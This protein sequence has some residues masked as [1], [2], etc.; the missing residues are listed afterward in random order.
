MQGPYW[1]CA[2]WHIL[3]GLCA[4]E[5]MLTSCPFPWQPHR[6]PTACV[7]CPCSY[8]HKHKCTFQHHFSSFCLLISESTEKAV[9]PSTHRHSIT[10]P[11]NSLIAKIYPW[12]I[13]TVYVVNRFKIKCHWHWQKVVLGFVTALEKKSVLVKAVSEKGYWFFVCCPRQKKSR[14]YSFH[15]GCC[16]FYC[17]VFMGYPRWF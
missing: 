2:T 10:F 8:P 16:K 13:S 3:L 9:S 5:T 12:V 4:K 6:F 7:W 17:H 1:F 15:K 14:G 11:T